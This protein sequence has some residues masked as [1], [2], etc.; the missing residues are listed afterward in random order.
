MTFSKKKTFY[1]YI[2]LYLMMFLLFKYVENK[3]LWKFQILKN[4]FSNNEISENFPIKNIY[5]EAKPLLKK[6]DINFF[7]LSQKL[8]DQAYL[9]FK[10][11]TLVYPARYKDN[12]NYFLAFNDEV[13]DGCNIIEKN[14]YLKLL[15]C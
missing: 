13:M 7:N 3:S 9:R 6:N 5:F 11:I 2:F 4:S 12:V 14:K 1:I 15:S 8:Y 10:I